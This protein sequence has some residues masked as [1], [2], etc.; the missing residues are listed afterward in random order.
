MITDTPIANP[1]DHDVDTLWHF[2]FGTYGHTRLYVWSTQLDSALEIACDWLADNAPGVFTTFDKDDY[3]A[4]C[5]TDAEREAIECLF[6]PSDG[7]QGRDSETTFR[8]CERAEVDHMQI[9]H[10]TYD[11]PNMPGPH[12]L[13]S[14]DW[15]VREVY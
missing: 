4:A 7:T 3:L 14:T 6:A 5:E 15:H 10:T 1:D 8:V 9:G 13:A 12:F 11:I 2:N